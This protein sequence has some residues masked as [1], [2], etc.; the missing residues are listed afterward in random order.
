MG[1]I[2]DWEEDY[3]NT[4]WW[5]VVDPKTVGQYTGIKDKNGT[6]IYESDI[7]KCRWLAELGITEIDCEAVGVVNWQDDICMFYIDFT[8]PFVTHPC[9]DGR[10]EEEGMPIEKTVDGFTKN[11]FSVD[12]EGYRQH[13]RQS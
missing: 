10:Y 5:A 7:V 9:E 12:Y 6:E 3:F 1:D 8:K 4:E 13:T 11:E 2:V